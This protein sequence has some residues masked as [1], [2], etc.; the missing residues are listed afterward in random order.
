MRVVIPDVTLTA[1][2]F[3]TVRCSSFISWLAMRRKE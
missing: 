2:G 1:H 3:Q